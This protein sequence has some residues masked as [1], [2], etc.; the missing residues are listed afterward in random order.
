[1][2]TDALDPGDGSY[3]YLARNPDGTLDIERMPVGYRRQKGPDGKII[4]L[5]VAPGQIHDLIAA[6]VLTLPDGVELGGP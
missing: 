6:G 5:D 3:P 2:A 4:L 1:M